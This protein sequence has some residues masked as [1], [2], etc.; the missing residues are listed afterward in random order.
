M[1]EGNVHRIR[2]IRIFPLCDVLELGIE[3]ASRLARAHVEQAFNDI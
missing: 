3:L 2:C 1:Q